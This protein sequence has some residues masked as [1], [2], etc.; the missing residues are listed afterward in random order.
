MALTQAERNRRYRAT[1]K[2]A[3]SRH[4]DNA[5]QRGVSFEL[6]FREWWLIWSVSGKW[7]SRGNRRGDYVM[8]RKGDVGPYAL[9]NVYIGKFEHNLHD[10]GAKSVIVRKHTARSTVVTF[11]FV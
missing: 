6:T 2:G 10:A 8:C 11:E 3:Y 9:G 5:T 1:P 4:R 7:H